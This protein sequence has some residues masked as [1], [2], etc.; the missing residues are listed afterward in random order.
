[1]IQ[2]FDGDRAVKMRGRL[3]SRDGSHMGGP[4]RLIAQENIAFTQRQSH[5][6]FQLSTSHLQSPLSAHVSCCN[7]R[8]QFEPFQAPASRCELLHV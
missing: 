5:R 6:Q 2:A 3:E 7:E 1:M 8:K 4:I